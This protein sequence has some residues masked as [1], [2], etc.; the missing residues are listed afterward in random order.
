MWCN[1]AAA[2]I[3]GPREESHGRIDT[4]ARHMRFY[5]GAF[6]HDKGMITAVRM[7]RVIIPMC[8]ATLLCNLWSTGLGN[9]VVQLSCNHIP[10]DMT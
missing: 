1:A 4:S 8:S 3:C 2:K 5:Q 6:S 9:E 7:D 10:G